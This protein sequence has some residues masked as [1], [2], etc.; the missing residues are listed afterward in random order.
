M[1]RKIVAQEPGLELRGKGVTES[2]VT[3]GS[4]FF[5]NVTL[6]KSRTIDCTEQ[7]F[8]LFRHFMYNHVRKSSTFT[9]QDLSLLEYS[10]FSKF[11]APKMC[12]FRHFFP[13]FLI[14]RLKCVNLRPKS[15]PF[16]NLNPDRNYHRN[17]AF[18]RFYIKT[19][20]INGGI[21]SLEFFIHLPE[22]LGITSTITVNSTSNNCQ[23][24]IFPS[25]MSIIKL[26]PIP[27]LKPVFFYSL[28]FS[29]TWRF[30]SKKYLVSSEL[31]PC[32]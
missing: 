25:S 19:Q 4:G 5:K 24:R 6:W 7:F 1:H 29:R 10:N 32:S 3:F 13:R 27:S 17:I 16:P 26:I 30:L 21:Q 15:A 12:H 31:F 14:F 20:Y 2:C 8:D 23:S 28:I 22:K 18:W 11:S 9:K